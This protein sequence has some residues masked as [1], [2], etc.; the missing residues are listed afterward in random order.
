[1]NTKNKIN[2]YWNLGIFA[3]FTL[4]VFALPDSILAANSLNQAMCKGVEMLKSDAGKALA[5]TAV[6]ILGLAALMGKISWGLGIMVV[7]GI[8]LLFGAGDIVN[9]IGGEGTGECAT[10]VTSS[11][12]TAGTY[13]PGSGT[14]PY[15]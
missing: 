7:L 12:G 9:T 15:R 3:V 6:I 14:P 10:A 8:A 11:G 5:I 13:V 1:M 2:I 4:M